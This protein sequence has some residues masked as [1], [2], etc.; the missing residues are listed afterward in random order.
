MTQYQSYSNFIRPHVKHLFYK[1]QLEQKLEQPHCSHILEGV[2]MTESLFPFY[3]LYLP[4]S[5]RPLG[6]KNSRTFANFTDWAQPT[7]CPY[8][9]TLSAHLSHKDNILLTF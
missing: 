3:I 6:L 2:T 9:E 4:G 1:W 8:R 5:Q 7:L